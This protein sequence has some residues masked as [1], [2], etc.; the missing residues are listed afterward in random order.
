M[1][2]RKRG[3]RTEVGQKFDLKNTFWIKAG[4]KINVYDY[5]QTASE[6]TDIYKTLEKYGS[7]EKIELDHEGVYGEFKE[8]DRMAFHEQLKKSEEL[9]KSLPFEV[10]AEFNNDKLQFMENGEKW[11]KN[12]IQAETKKVET[13]KEEVTDEQK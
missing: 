10:R 4:K 5:I 3:D 2:F 13:K 1:K 9:W 7:L 6:D 12:K 8:M 11:L